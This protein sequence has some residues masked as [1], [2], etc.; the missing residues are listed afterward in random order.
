MTRCLYV[1]TLTAYGAPELTP[2][3][4]KLDEVWGAALEPKVIFERPRLLSRG[5]SGCEF[6]YKRS[7]NH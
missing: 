3:F 2:V 6:C 4:C 7:D 1:N 5:D